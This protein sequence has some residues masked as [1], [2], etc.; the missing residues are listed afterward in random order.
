MRSGRVFDS[1]FDSE[2]DSKIDSELAANT[3]G[4]NSG[5]DRFDAEIISNNAERKDRKMC[6][7]GVNTGQLELMIEQIDDHCK[8]ERR[9]AHNLAH[10]AADAGFNTVSEKLHAA[11]SLLDDV[12]ALLDEAKDAIEDDAEAGAGVTVS[13]V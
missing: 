7:N 12:R 9:W 10:T 11:Q 13:L 6:T 5:I 8:L 2:V 3:D 4:R 1:E